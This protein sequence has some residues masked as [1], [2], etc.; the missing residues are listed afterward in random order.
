VL[1]HYLLRP[2]YFRKVVRRVLQQNAL[3][4]FLWAIV[5][6]ISFGLL[7][8]YVERDAQDL[9][10]ADALWWSMVT[11]TTVGYGDFYAKTF[12]GRFIISYPC[13]IL[14]IGLIGYLV[15]TVANAF[16][17]FS[18]RKR[19]GL[20]QVH[21]K[22]H[23]VL[24]NYPGEEKVKRVI[25]ELQSIDEYRHARIVLVT[26]RLKELPDSLR[27]MDV[28][29]VKG[30]PTQAEVLLRADIIRCSG[31]I[32]L[33]RNTNA[34]ESDE[35]TFTVAS[36]IKQ[37]GREKNTAIKVVTE[38]VSENSIP[39][40]KELDV[41]GITSGEGV[42]S[43]LLAQ[44]F[45]NPGINKVFAEIITSR[46]GSEFYIS[47]AETEGKSMRELWQAALDHDRSI[48]I[49]GVRRGGRNMLNPPKDAILKNGDRL[50]ILAD[51][52]D[53]V[54]LFKKELHN[55]VKT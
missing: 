35:R 26:E 40:M 42:P 30:T 20:M 18:A 55:T 9:S 47:D 21:E 38:L 31:V 12:I 2:Q 29:F 16:I 41:A 17:D 15:G 28:V 24:C 8:Y 33:A 19:G 27:K 11:M 23:V 39:I 51:S 13:M 46:M 36:V 43:C 44:E 14:G 37:I 45:V 32:V 25:I 7:F 5:L 54:N 4:I 50:I 1:F 6:N 52:S 10:I 48:Q 49:L 3:M 22:E 34:V 53:D